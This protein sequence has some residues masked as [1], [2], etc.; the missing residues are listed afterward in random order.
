MLKHVETK[1]L[2][3]KD[4]WVGDETMLWSYREPQLNGNKSWLSSL[5]K[6]I[7]WNH[8]TSLFSCIHHCKS[9]NG[10]PTPL[11]QY[12]YLTSSLF[13]FF[14]FLS[15][16]S[17]SL[18]LSHSLFPF[19]LSIFLN[20]LF[21]CLSLLVPLSLSLSSSFCRSSNCLSGFGVHVNLG[22]FKGLPSN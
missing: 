14:L 19:I 9:L 8:L 5:P 11:Y 17:L 3:K 15:F 4:V 22:Q 16:F 12:Q 13:K 18:S 20:L 6:N 10:S 1:T 7:L 2:L 21:F